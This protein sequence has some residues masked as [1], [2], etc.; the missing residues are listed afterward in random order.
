MPG[1]DNLYQTNYY[2]NI[3]AKNSDLEEKVLLKD[4]F[5][6]INQIY[7]ESQK[8]IRITGSNTE[9]SAVAFAENS[10]IINKIINENPYV[11]ETLYK[12]REMEDNTNY[13]TRLDATILQCESYINENNKKK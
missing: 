4:E 2:K 11:L 9:N 13:L 1:Y 12:I 7:I 3:V 10:P 8:N 5:E 6:L